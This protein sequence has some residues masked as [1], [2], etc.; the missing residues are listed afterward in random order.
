MK[1]NT[2]NQTIVSCAQRVPNPFL[3]IRSPF[4]LLFLLLIGLNAAA[5]AQ[6]ITYQK[7]NVSLKEVFKEITRQTGYDLFYSNTKLNDSRKLNVN[8]KN[9]DL[10]EVLNDLIGTDPFSYTID[11]KAVVLKKKEPSFL[12]RVID[13]LKNINVHGMVM[14]EDGVPL[15]GATVKIKGANRTT[16]TNENGAFS[17]ENV[18]ENA[19]LVISYLGYERKEISASE[20][21]GKVLLLKILNKLEEV[22]VV[23]TGYQ[24]LP[25]ERATGSFNI[26]TGKQIENKLPGSVTELLEGLAPGFN[27]SRVG[28]TGAPSTNIRGL[29]TLESASSQ[30]GINQPLYVIDGFPGDVTTVNPQDIENVTFLKDAAA[31]SIWGG[32]ASNGVV[33][34][35]T[36]RSKKGPVSIEYSNNFSTTGD[37]SLGKHNTY[38]NSSETVDFLSKAYLYYY[39]PIGGFTPDPAIISNPVFQ[40]LYDK[41]KGII[42]AATAAQKLDALRNTDNLEQIK[43]YEFQRPVVMQH[44]LSL[45]GSG[46]RYGYRLSLGYYSNKGSTQGN[47]DEN[48]LIN[49][50]SNYEIT[51]YLSLYTG[52]QTNFGNVTSNIDQVNFSGAAVNNAIANFSP[53]T[54]FADE[55]GN[56]IRQPGDLTDLGDKAFTDLGYLSKMNPYLNV[57]NDVNQKISKFSGRFQAGSLVKILPGFNLDVKFQY[58]RDYS[59]TRNLLDGTSF[60]MRDLI[61]RFTIINNGKLYY[62]IPQGSRL[63]TSDGTNS[64]INLRAVLNYDHTFGKDHQITA[65][66]GGERSRNQASSIDA[67]AFGYSDQLLSSISLLSLVKQLPA[68]VSV[69]RSLPADGITKQSGTDFRAVSAFSNAGY[70]Y[71]QKYTV[72]ASVRLDETNLWGRDSNNA[73]KP[74]WSFGGKWNA[75]RENFLKEV[76][77]INGL[78]VRATYGIGG[79]IVYT[80]SPSMVLWPST[81]V[82]NPALGGFTILSPPND[83][84]TWEKT[85]TQN[86]GLDFDVLDHRIS[87]SIDYYRRH[88][89]DVLG[90]GLVNP[91]LGFSS[92]KLNTS[93]LQNN[94]LEVQLKTENIRTKTF[95]WSTLFNLSYNNNKIVKNYQ[96]PSDA[97]SLTSSI[98]N[99]KSGYPVSAIF[100]FRYAGLDAAGLP[101]AYDENNQRVPLVTNPDALRYMGTQIPPYTLGVTNTFT[102]KQFSLQF[103]V[104]GNFGGKM[105]KEVTGGWIGN[106]VNFNKRIK[107]YNQN[108]WWKPGDE[109]T[110][111]VPNILNYID[112]YVFKQ[113]TAADINVDKSDYIKLRELI[114]SYSLPTRFLKKVGI[115][116]LSINAQARNIWYWAANSDKYDPEYI[117]ANNGVYTTPAPI[118]YALGLRVMF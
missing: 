103:L 61:N 60:T 3:V 90:T 81:S 6:K 4:L 73:Y 13:H 30:P 63:N 78:S 19:I 58:T 97:Y 69:S 65:I 18:K 38:M 72:T 11:G 40:T 54:L 36:K 21:M 5:V 51:K 102:Y 44:N 39:G 117:D 108:V 55:A 67:T 98:A 25:K 100:A 109:N 14:G 110:T 12:E 99:R 96:P 16:Q 1:L 28:N 113:W 85:Y 80:T 41:D 116:S 15:A 62:T 52:L 43:K 34:I 35:T 118:T 48:L 92:A 2:F 23:S 82:L 104:V 93:E 57:K 71:K 8:Y 7:K 95:L 111:N 77:W 68:G 107:E 45:S 76:S 70:T 84:L 50:N 24:R 9:A 22:S 26:V 106:L 86:F 20:N 114:V 115:G 66:L 49:L 105:H 91:T 46:E 89:V 94:G 83:K 75:A 88:S 42:D 56:P 64:A 101:T 27:L 37:L 33:V 10:K 17:L 29:S 31:A 47:K 87:G 112:P 79:N 74:I 32:R 59:K 53:F